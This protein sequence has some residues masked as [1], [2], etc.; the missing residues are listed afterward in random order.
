[1]K[2]KKTQFSYKFN[3]LNRFTKKTDQR[4][5]KDDTIQNLFESSQVNPG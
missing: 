2:G 4:S 3:I 5:M 1:V